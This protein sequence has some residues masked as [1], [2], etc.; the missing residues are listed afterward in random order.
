MKIPLLAHEWIRFFAFERGE[1]AALAGLGADECPYSSGLNLN[2]RE[3][4]M[5]GWVYGSSEGVK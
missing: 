1:I 2:V 5:R 3:L 4:W